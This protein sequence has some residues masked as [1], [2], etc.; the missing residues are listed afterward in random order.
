MK[1]M[2]LKAAVVLTLG[3]SIY[4]CSDDDDAGSPVTKKQV[5]ENYS[6][7]VY[8]NYQKAYDDAVVLEA[9][10][11][12][13]TETPTE[14]TLE[15][16]KAK[17]KLSRESYGTTE[18]FR[19]ANGP[20]DA[21]EESP[22]GLINSWP[23]DEAF[24][25]YV[26]D[27][28]TITNNGI[29]AS[30]I[31]ITKDYLESENG[32]GGEANVSVGYHAIE[33]L[34]WGQDLTA[35]SADLPGQRPLTDYTTDTYAGRRAQYLKV[36]ADL[37]TDHLAYLVNQWKVGGEY[38]TTF[39][40][41]DENQAITNIYLGITTLAQAELAVE[42]MDVALISENQE[43][44]HSCFSDNTHRDIALNLQGIVNVYEGHYGSVDGASLQDLV[45]QANSAVSTDTN[46]S[47]AAAL[48]KI[49]AIKRPFDLAISGGPESEEGAKVRTA[50]RELE[51]LGANFIAGAS[52]IGIT[53]NVI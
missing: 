16:A 36:C 10:I 17:W 27:N 18:A 15:A 19:F 7:I 30:S 40:T 1:Q 22:E 37:L 32:N 24:I 51:N 6:N 28:G 23:L 39:L 38:R 2:T 9:A 4:A 31:A 29:I 44:E 42:R 45:G 5:I 47:I 8:A 21:T 25:D 26:N 35:P 46:N 3:L 34:L 14:T 12:D 33:F 49:A 53:V 50:V 13:F 11:D 41:M 48:S 20:I 43:D 52:K